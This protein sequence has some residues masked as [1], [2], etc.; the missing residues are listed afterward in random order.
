MTENVKAQMKKCFFYPPIPNAKV[1][2]ETS[3]SN[4]TLGKYD[5]PDGARFNVWITNKSDLTLS[6]PIQ[7]IQTKGVIINFV[8]IKDPKL[9]SSATGTPVTNDDKELVITP[10]DN[11]T[12]FALQ[13][14]GNAIR[15]VTQNKPAEI[16][17]TATV[18]LAIY[19]VDSAKQIGV[20]KNGI[21]E[22]IY[23]TCIK[24]FRLKFGIKGS[25]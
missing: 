16:L 12:T 10:P 7:A 20:Y 4:I 2:V 21:Y 22:P 15:Q 3:F 8:N 23:Y 1:L 17:A 14:L 9:Q 5:T 11:T 18:R 13:N 19:F 6:F 24:Q 25:K